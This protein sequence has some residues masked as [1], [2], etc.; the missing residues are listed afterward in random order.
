MIF[1]LKRV[2]SED[3]LDKGL[4]QVLEQIHDKR[5]Y[6]GIKGKVILVGMAFCGKIP[7]VRIEMIE[8]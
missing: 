6:L 4:D 7:K 2:G 5:Y 1:E 3:M 8:V